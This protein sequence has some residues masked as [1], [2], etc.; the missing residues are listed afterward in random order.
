M[1]QVYR[2]VSV[3]DELENFAIIKLTLK[4]LPIELLH[5]SNGEDAIRLLSTTKP[6]LVLLDVTLPDMRGWDVLDKLAEDGNKLDGVPVVMLT[7][8]TELTHRVIARFQGVTAYL[9]KPFEPSV[10]RDQV[11]EVLGLTT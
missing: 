8:H 6:D 3:E 11:R 5:A 4:D 7:S 1:S 10:L 2:V 9:N